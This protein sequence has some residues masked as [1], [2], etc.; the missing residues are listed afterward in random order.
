MQRKGFTLIELLVV[1]AIIGILA[2]ILL[3]ALARARE[4]ARRASCAN[5]LKQFGIIFKMYASEAPAERFPPAFSY[6]GPVVNCEGNYEQTGTGYR[7]NLM[8]ADFLSLYPEY[9][10]DVDIGICPSSPNSRPDEIVVNSRGEELWGYVCDEASWEFWPLAPSDLA[11]VSYTYMAWL[12][13]KAGSNDPVV[14]L[15]S[16][17]PGGAWPSVPVTGQFAAFWDGFSQRYAPLTDVSECAERNKI[18]DSDV[19]MP[20]YANDW[21]M[22]NSGQSAGNGAGDII[23]RTRE[24][25]ERFMITDINNPGASA[26]AQSDIAVMWDQISTNLAAYN[27]VPGGSNV[28][29]MDGH[30]AFLRYPNKEYPV[31]PEFAQIF[32]VFVDNWIESN[33]EDLAA[34]PACGTE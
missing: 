18:V 9:W 6:W 8:E 26:M 17:W 25:I 4:A 21:Y 22:P 16:V 2:A 5:N 31:N 32:G 14:D 23:F 27:H 3:P 15:N 29:Y 33:I 12:L 1:I 19:P 34:A 24:G 28:L 20:D 30:V 13:D 7:E 11:T 10:N